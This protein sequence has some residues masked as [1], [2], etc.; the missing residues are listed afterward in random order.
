MYLLIIIGRETAHN[1]N[2]STAT[3]VNLTCMAAIAKDA[4]QALAAMCAYTLSCIPFRSKNCLHESYVESWTELQIGACALVAYCTN[5]P[6]SCQ[7]TVS[8]S[9]R[10]STHIPISHNTGEKHAEAV[11]VALNAFS[12]IDVL[13]CAPQI[14]VVVLMAHRQLR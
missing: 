13:Q 1:Q 5:P 9:N 12:L 4:A 2:N 11:K 14:C 10:K 3:H 6:A 8:A 7:L